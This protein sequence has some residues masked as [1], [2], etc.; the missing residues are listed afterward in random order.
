MC[1]SRT[2]ASSPIGCIRR[3]KRKRRR[4]K[5]ARSSRCRFELASG[6]VLRNFKTSRRNST[7]NTILKHSSTSIKNRSKRSGKR[8]HLGHRGNIGA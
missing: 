2:R 8:Y 7:R 4:P 3:T 1:G 5:H 6:R